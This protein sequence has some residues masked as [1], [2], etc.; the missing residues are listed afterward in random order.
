MIKAG[1]TLEYT[2]VLTVYGTYYYSYYA[3]GS[4]GQTV[5]S[6][7]IR[8]SYNKGN[9]PTVISLNILPIKDIA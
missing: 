9:H 8:V 7:K 5:E 2:D 1:E 4:S 6:N 3:I